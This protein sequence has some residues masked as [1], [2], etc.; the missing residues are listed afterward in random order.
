ME[1]ELGFRERV[2]AVISRYLRNEI[3]FDAGANELAAVLRSIM[4]PPPGMSNKPAPPEPRGP[5]KIKTL[6]AD[7][8][9]NPKAAET[10]IGGVLHA[11]PLAP[12]GSPED[13][14]KAQRFSRRR[15]V[16]LKARVRA[17]SNTRLK[18]TAPSFCGSLLFVKSSMS[19]RSL[20][21]FR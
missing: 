12:G 15:F 19:R 11:A 10:P 17:P 13:E 7:E 1:R 6:S 14:D 9:M 20:S 3:E 16:A 5:I 21:A 2:E 8:W 18:L 4:S